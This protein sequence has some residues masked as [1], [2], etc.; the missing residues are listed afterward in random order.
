MLIGYEDILL[1][2]NGHIFILK[3]MQLLIVKFL[4]LTLTLTLF[5]PITSDT[6]LQ[7]RYCNLSSTFQKASANYLNESSSVWGV[8]LGIACPDVHVS[9]IVSCHLQLSVSRLIKGHSL[10]PLVAFAYRCL[11]IHLFYPTSGKCH[12]PWGND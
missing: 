7:L 11:V 4:Q 10:W 3:F 8:S 1:Y 6:Q 9:L 2:C 5:R 12:S